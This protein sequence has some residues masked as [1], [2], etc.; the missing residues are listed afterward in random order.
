M[1]ACP[2][3]TAHNGDTR[4]DSF[5]DASGS[6]FSA[7][8]NVIER[9]PQSGHPAKAAPGGEHHPGL[10]GFPLADGAFIYIQPVGQPDISQGDQ[11]TDDCDIVHRGWLPVFSTDQRIA[12]K[13]SG[14][15]QLPDVL[16][17]ISIHNESA[18]AGC[19]RTGFSGV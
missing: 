13:L 11:P 3:F 1:T 18:C 7:T 10:A 6:G 4:D 12:V 5:S 19:H 2:I 16:F 17:I 9:H 14:L 8:D 15:D